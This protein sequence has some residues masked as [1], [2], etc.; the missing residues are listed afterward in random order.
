MLAV[1]MGLALAACATP[2]TDPVARAEFEQV[3]DPLEPMNRAIFDFNLAFDRFFLRPLAELY[4][5]VLPQIVRDGIRNA[6]DNLSLPLVFAN[7]VLQG[8]FQRAG[9]T[10]ARLGVN[11]TLGIAGIFDVAARLGIEPH[12]EDLG[13]TLAVWGVGS[14]P[15]LMLPVFGPR[16]PRQLIGSIAENLADPFNWYIRDISHDYWPFVRDFVSGIDVRARNIETLDEIERTS[17][18]FYATIR[19]LYRQHRDA[20]I[21]NGAPAA[22]DLT[23]D[24]LLFSDSDDQIEVTGAAPATARDE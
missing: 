23:D 21:R 2:P 13:Q 5:A 12:D 19:S 10:V 3:N 18:D 9:E 14:G 4:R 1:M 16:P 15:Y 6:A 22:D 7:D 24:E 17:I 20:Q 8:E 11:S